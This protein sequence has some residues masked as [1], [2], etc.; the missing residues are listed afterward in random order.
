M[1]AFG[2]GQRVGVADGGSQYR[3]CIGKI[4]RIIVHEN[5][6]SYLVKLESWG[7]L[8]WKWLSVMSTWLRPM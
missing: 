6:V 2:A 3:R 5:Q 1:E 7:T 4:V 8:L